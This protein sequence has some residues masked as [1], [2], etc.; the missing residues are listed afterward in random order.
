MIVGYIF[1]VKKEHTERIFNQNKCIL[2]YSYTR[3]KLHEGHK[4]LFYNPSPISALVGGA[5]IIAIRQSSSKE[6]L[7]NSDK[8]CQTKEEL[9]DY[10]TIS[11]TVWTGKKKRDKKYF[12]TIEF[13]NSKKYSIAIKMI[14]PMIPNGYYILKSEYD[15]YIKQL[16]E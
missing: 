3:K 12:T 9:Q 1:P 10:L 8:T 16:K 11:P 7:A 13:H 15:F 6:I 5:E 2:V 14:K 4:I